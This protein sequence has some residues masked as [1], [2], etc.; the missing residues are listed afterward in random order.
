MLY[1]HVAIDRRFP[2]S[3]YVS[4][5]VATGWRQKWLLSRSPNAVLMR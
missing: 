2:A 3:P 1:Q 5:A 4:I